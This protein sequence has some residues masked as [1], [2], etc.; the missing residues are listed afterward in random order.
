MTPADQRLFAKYFDVPYPLN[1]LVRFSVTL[2][3]FM[4]RE[5]IRQMKRFYDVWLQANAPESDDIA[6][7]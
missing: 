2:S 1:P 4:G 3:M 6:E 7:P 5:E